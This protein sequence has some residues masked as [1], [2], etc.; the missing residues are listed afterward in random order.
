IARLATRSNIFPLY[1]IE[2]GTDWTL[3]LEGDLPVGDYL[4]VQGRFRHLTPED[5]EQ[6]QQEVDADLALIQERV[7]ATRVR[8]AHLKPET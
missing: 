5:L 3:N 2:N 4:G 7:A 8:K 6:I 1:E